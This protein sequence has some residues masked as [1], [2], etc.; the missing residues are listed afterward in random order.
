MGTRI[1]VASSQKSLNYS[2]RFRLQP[3]SSFREFKIPNN[4]QLNLGRYKFSSNNLSAGSIVSLGGNSVVFNGVGYMETASSAVLALDAAF[5]IE[6][7]TKIST[8]QGYQTVYEI[9]TYQ[10][11][12]LYR[13]GN[14]EGNGGVW[15]NGGQYVTASAVPESVGSWRHMAICRNA[16]NVMSIFFNGTRVWTATLSGT[17]NSGNAPIRMGGSRHTSGQYFYGNISQC[18]IVKGS[19]VYDPTQTT[20]TIP[21]ATLTSITNTTAFLC[22]ASSTLTDLGPNN[23]SITTGGTAPTVSSDDPFNSVDVVVGLSNTYSEMTINNANTVYINTKT[24]NARKFGE[25]EAQLEL[26]AFDAVQVKLVMKS[27]NSSKVPRIKDL[28]VISY[29]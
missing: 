9:G 28:R 17:V 23:L 3:T 25:V 14:Q 24:E 26:P 5:T 20:I 15:I 18:R 21:T 8:S 11:G 27:V 12:I 4:I 10:N 22:Q 13:P 2:E 6:V 29:A 16:S 1:T 19:T 7:W